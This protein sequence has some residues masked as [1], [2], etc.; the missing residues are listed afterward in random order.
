MGSRPLGFGPNA[1]LVLYLFPVTS[2]ASTDS[3]ENVVQPER[4]MDGYAG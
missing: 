2:S 4:W 1:G 3:D